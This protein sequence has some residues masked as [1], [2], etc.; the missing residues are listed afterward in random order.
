MMWRNNA[1]RKCDS[2][3]VLQIDV[4]KKGEMQ[5]HELNGKA[6]LVH[7]IGTARKK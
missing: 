3:F 1:L 5:S 7:V 4:N 6:P 2:A